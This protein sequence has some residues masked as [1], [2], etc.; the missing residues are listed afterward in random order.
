[1]ASSITTA[2]AHAHRTIVL[3]LE[4]HRLT[5]RG[6]TPSIGQ[7]SVL[8]NGVGAVLVIIGCL[9]R[10]STVTGLLGSA[11]T[12]QIRKY[13]QASKYLGT[14]LGRYLPAAR[15]SGY[16]GRSIRAAAHDSD[17]NLTFFS[18]RVAKRSCVCILILFAAISSVYSQDTLC[19]LAS[20]ERSYC[21]TRQSGNLTFTLAGFCKPFLPVVAIRRLHPTNPP[22]LTRIEFNTH[23]PSYY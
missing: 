7:R 2:T 12:V 8:W 1:M 13:L 16:L 5:Q 11:R 20:L 22:P 21:V 3:G 17:D 10:H 6:S 19:C 14:Y 4:F 15:V 18:H 9:V 23:T